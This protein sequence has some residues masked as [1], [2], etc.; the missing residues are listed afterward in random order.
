M[1]FVQQGAEL[2]ALHLPTIGH[3]DDVAP[4]WRIS[5]LCEEGDPCLLK[6]LRGHENRGP[7]AQREIQRITRSRIDFMHTVPHLH[8]DRCVK[9]VV[10]QLRDRHPFHRQSRLPVTSVP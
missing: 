8:P 7:H 10:A 6:Q 3:T 2:G 9:D 1:P 4:L 5:L